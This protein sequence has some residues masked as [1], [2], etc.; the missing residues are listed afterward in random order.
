MIRSSLCRPAIAALSLLL[1]VAALPAAADVP[2]AALLANTPQKTASGA[3]YTAPASWTMSAT[4]GVTVWTPPEGDLRIAF[5][6]LTGA[7]DG[8][9][10]IAKAWAQWQPDFKRSASLAQ[11]LPGRQGWDAG[12][13]IAY[14]TSPAEHAVVQAIAS[15]HGATTTVILI[16]GSAATAEKRSSDAGLIAASLRPGD[17]ARE[18][19]SG[20]TAHQ[21]DSRRITQ[22]M[23]FVSTAMGELKIPGVGIALSDHGRIVY[24]GGL[25]VRDVATKAAVDANTR[26]MIA[27]NTKGLSTLLLAKMVDLGKVRW[28]EPVV[29]V[30]PSFRLGDDTVTKSVL[31]KHLVCAC[32]GVPRKDMEWLL[33]T[34]P[35]TPA[36][37]T[38]A[39]LAATAPT[40]KFGEVFQ[41]NNLM[42]TAAGYIAGHLAYPD[43]EIGAAYDRSMQTFIFDPLGMSRTTFSM[44][45][46]LADSDHAEPFGL[47]IDGKLARD[48]QDVN[49]AIAPF[50]P[51]GGA[52]STP[53]DMIRYVDDELALGKLPSGVQL[54]SEKNLLQRR[55]RTVAIGEDGWYGMGLMTDNRYGIPIVHHG[56]DL[57]GY[58][59]DW[60]AFPDAQVG[61]VIL[62]NSDQGPILR[63]QFMRRILELMYDGKPEA[64]E[65]VATSEKQIVAAQIAER[66]RLTVPVPSA[67]ASMFASRYTNPDL[68]PMVVRYDGAGLSFRFN[69]LASHV[70]ARKND[71]GSTS[72]V[73]IDPGNDGFEF[74]FGTGANAKNLLLRDGQHVYTFTP[75]S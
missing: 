21:L 58:H 19:F 63:G 32:T 71:D 64:A 75:S 18:M 36:T 44:R 42:A 51:A 29:E 52:W 14:E 46:A 69:S 5:V 13:V 17:Y 61:A 53:H 62:T 37:Q 15:R 67:L 43:M 20:K 60:F 11:D 12:T 24:E 54:V 65:N 59:S 49:E 34:N 26:F 9:D 2:S 6:E 40:S 74:A 57:A 22:L 16:D 27:S 7:L 72:Y 25:G 50:R 31:L 73:T 66:P 10:A 1:F 70:A 47:D 28:D 68:G 8:K 41:Y 39:Y 56:G 38:F 33:N 45:A 3:T 35:Q 55:E 30:Y 4:N 48:S 23:A